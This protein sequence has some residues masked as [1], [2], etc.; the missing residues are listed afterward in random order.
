MSKDREKLVVRELQ[1]LR[2]M[3]SQ[4]QADWNALRRAGGK[5]RASFLVSLYEL[6]SRARRVEIFLED[7]FVGT[8]SRVA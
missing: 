1:G 8:E 5:V 3:E 6:E 2:E 4:L 7:S